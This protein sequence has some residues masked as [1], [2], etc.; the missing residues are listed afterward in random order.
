ML[1]RS[2]LRNG[3]I[4]RKT[5]C[6]APLSRISPILSPKLR[7]PSESMGKIALSH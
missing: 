3:A 1:L 6:I 4:R 2:T 7:Q 5:F